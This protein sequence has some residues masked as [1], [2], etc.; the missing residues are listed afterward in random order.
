MTGT[1]EQRRRDYA[2]AMVGQLGVPAP[3]LENAFAAVPREAFM[4]PGSWHLWRPPEGRQ[5]LET[6][7][8]M[9][10]YPLETT[11]EVLV[12]L[13]AEHGINN[14]SPSLHAQML[15]ALAVRPGHHILHLGAGTGYYTA[16]LAELTGP[17]GRVTA[18]EY[19]PHLAA[20]ARENLAPW[21]QAHVTQGDAAT[22]PTAN[23]D[24]LYVN[25]AVADPP[26]TWFAR[27]NPDGV[28][29]LPLG[30]GHGRI[31]RVER[32]AQGFAASFLMPCGFITASGPLAGSTAHRTRLDAAFAH[33]N[34]EA[35]RSLHLDPATPQQ[36][37]FRTPNWALSPE[38]PG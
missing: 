23:I 16:L 11:P 25:F 35:V 17:Q 10:L 24:R 13:D 8:P 15:H 28:A 37:W 3:A 30:T 32:I 33:G 7:D 12:V 5:V 22:F 29:I 21:P 19:Q 14:G 34:T 26:P 4:P 36:A 18:V 20:Q 38:P 31:L 2:R 9:A 27:L 6:N 1:L